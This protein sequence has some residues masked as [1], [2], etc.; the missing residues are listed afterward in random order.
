M[1]VHLRVYAYIYR[2]PECSS[3]K[4]ILVC[5]S[6]LYRPP[7]I[8]TLPCFKLPHISISKSVLLRL[9]NWLLKSRDAYLVCL[10]YLKGHNVTSLRRGRLGMAQRARALAAVQPD[11]VSPHRGGDKKR[12]PRRKCR[13][14]PSRQ[15]PVA[16]HHRSTLHASVQTGHR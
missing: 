11:R 16:L 13:S 1:W 6:T 9:Q 5:P 15:P 10:F 8:T 3:S 2:E 12:S 7:G 4:Q 14:R